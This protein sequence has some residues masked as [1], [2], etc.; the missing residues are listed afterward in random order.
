MVRQ[1]RLLSL[2]RHLV[3]ID[4]QNA[5]GNETRIAAFVKGY[6]E[7]AGSASRIYAFKKNRSNVVAALKNSR[8]RSSLLITPHLDTVPAGV[9]WKMRPF[10]GRIR[11]GRLYGLGA[12][13]CKVNLACSLEALQSLAEDKATLGYNLIFAATAD[14]E[15]GSGF[16]LIPL[17][18]KGILK[19]DAALVLDA[20]DFEIIVAQKGL[21]HLRLCLRGRR[22]HGAYPWLGENA[23]EKAVEA[24]REIASGE[25]LKRQTEKRRHPLLKEATVN[26]GTIKGGDKVNVVADWCESELDYRYLPGDSAERILK[27]IRRV[28]NR[29]SARF[30]LEI[31][32]IQKP[33]QIDA[34]H[35]LVSCLRQAM[36]ENGLSGRI[37]GSE[38]ATTITFFQDRDIPAIA[39][40][41]GCAGQAHVPDEYVTLRNLYKGAYVLE[42]FLKGYAL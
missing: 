37:R 13:D 2:L 31:E 19:P 5:P 27:K 41:F 29:L 18:E 42:T 28:L 36:R 32:G 38:G 24:L 39:T 30:R 20:D 25:F 6:L 16:G 11:Q 23:I 1:R 34:G 7:R 21:L 4:S 35:P 9:S 17:L 33:Y 12:T 3:S 8:A 15:S 22:A 40:G 14:E 10:A 26:I